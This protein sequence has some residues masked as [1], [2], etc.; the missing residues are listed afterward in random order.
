[1]LLYQPERFVQIAQEFNVPL[2]IANISA[3][4]DVLEKRFQERV[5]KKKADPT[6]RIANT[7]P[8]R[9]DELYAMYYETKMESPLEFDS[10]VSTPEEIADVIV[11]YIQNAM[12]E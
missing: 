8:K 12:K 9:F 10:S 2:F 3:P 6:V 11:K 1:V 5:D 4:K 7:D